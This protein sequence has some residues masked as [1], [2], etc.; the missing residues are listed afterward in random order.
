VTP[1]EDRWEPLSV[2]EPWWTVP[3]PEP[4][5]VPMEP[6]T[7]EDPRSCPLWMLPVEGPRGLVT[8]EEPWMVLV[9]VVALREL[10]PVDEM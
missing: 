7:V 1:E 10:L 6:L 8:V 5:E 9:L 2:E 3:V 4:V